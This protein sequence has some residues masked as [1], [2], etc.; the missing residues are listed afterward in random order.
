MGHQGQ[1]GQIGEVL[2]M[3]LQEQVPPLTQEAVADEPQSQE[4]ALVA[5]VR[6]VP[7]RPGRSV[8][9]RPVCV[10]TMT[11]RAVS[12]RTMAQGVKISPIGR[13]PIRVTVRTVVPVW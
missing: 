5:P 13:P 1:M 7:V 3:D 2:L 12:I 6:T 10:D 4:L 11:V 9:I 8:T